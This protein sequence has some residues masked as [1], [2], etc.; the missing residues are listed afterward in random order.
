MSAAYADLAVETIA[1]PDTALS[2]ENGQVSWQVRNLG[3]AATDLVLWSDRIV[4]SR[5]LTPSADDIVLAGAI[6]HARILEPGQSY[7]ARA[8]LTLP[9]DL[10]GDFYVLVDVNSARTVTENGLTGNNVG[11]SAALLR[12]SLAPAADLSATDVTGPTQ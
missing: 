10:Q 7:L 3:N 5:D 11:S 4:L 6:T 1:A 8:T 12:I 9:R 2:G